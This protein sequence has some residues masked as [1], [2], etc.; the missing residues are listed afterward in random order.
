MT[1]SAVP[2]TVLHFLTYTSKNPTSSPLRN[3]AT[4]TARPWEVKTSQSPPSH[5]PPALPSISALTNG[6]PDAGSSGLSSPVS[7]RERDSGAWSQPQST[8]T[9]F[10]SAFGEPTDEKGSSTYSTNTSSYPM[11]SATNS[12]YM[13]PNRMS[14][15]SN[16]SGHGPTSHSGADYTGV[17]SAPSMDSP[18]YAH[19]SGAL[20]A[21][22]HHHHQ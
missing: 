7:T 18:H 22:D 2:E 1:R 15:F 17:T 16:S 9:S 21:I 12:Y 4:T 14:N 20:P 10:R 13:S 5:P 11:S 6:L 8:R 19:H 3:M